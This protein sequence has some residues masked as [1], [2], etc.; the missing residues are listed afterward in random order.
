MENFVKSLY[1]DCAFKNDEARN[2]IE[3][4]LSNVLV[5]TPNPKLAIVFFT[6]LLC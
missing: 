4:D 3:S 5:F 1:E 6:L 2:E